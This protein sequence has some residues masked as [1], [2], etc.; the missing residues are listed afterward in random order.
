[1]NYI[2]NK[3]IINSNTIKYT[4]NSEGGKL[5]YHNFLNLLR[6]KNNEF[7]KAF[8]DELNIASSEFSGYFWEC[9]PV[10]SNTIDKDFE[11]VVVKSGALSNIRQD[12]SNFQEYFGRDNNVVSF[13]SFSGD[14]LIVPIPKDSDYKNISKFADNTSAEQWGEF[15][16]KVGEKME[17]NLINANGSTRWLST[18][19]LAVYYLHVRIDKKPKYYN[20]QEYLKETQEYQEI[21]PKTPQ[22][23][24]RRG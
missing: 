6:E 16:Q 2:F 7:L 22:Y 10:S 14:T 13:S 20:H 24:F 18:S 17:E 12:Y 23:P 21:P 11:F 9:V 15:W 19:G 1:M 8:R 4:V 5:T 3:N